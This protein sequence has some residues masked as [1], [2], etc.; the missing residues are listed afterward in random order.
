MTSVIAFAHGLRRGDKPDARPEMLFRLLLDTGIKKSEAMRLTPA[1]VTRDEPPTLIVRHQSAKNVYKERIIPLDPV[2]LDVLDEYLAQYTPQTTIINC[3]AR[4]L[5][6]ILEDLG[7]GA[8]I[9]A[10]NLVRD[11]A[12]DVRRS[13]LPRRR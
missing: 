5:E 6:Y 1:D 13:R 10:E 11:A 12:L 4:N 7:M 8:G 3:T 2:W 9:A